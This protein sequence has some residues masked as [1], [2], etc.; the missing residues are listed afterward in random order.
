MSFSLHTYTIEKIKTIFCK[1]VSG[2]RKRV[3]LCGEGAQ[4]SRRDLVRDVRNV[5]IDVDVPV[6]VGV[7]IVGV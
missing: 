1:I 6:A 7:V 3:Q 5:R 2:P 4:E